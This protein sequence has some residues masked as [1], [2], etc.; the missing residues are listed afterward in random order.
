VISPAQ[1]AVPAGKSAEL[2]LITPGN[3][4]APLGLLASDRAVTLTIPAAQLNGNIAL[5]ELAVS[6]E[7]PGGSP[8]GQPTGPIISA[9][10]FTPL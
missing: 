2:W 7:P 3:K 9:A 8:T 6:I 1:V 4:P 10:K 5:A